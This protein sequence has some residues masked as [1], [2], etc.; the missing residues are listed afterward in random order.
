ML[1]PSGT[2]KEIDAAIAVFSFGSGV[3]LHLRST[4]ALA[5]HGAGSSTGLVA[6]AHLAGDAQSSIPPGVR[7]FAALAIHPSAP[8]VVAM[9]ALV[10][11]ERSLH[12]WREPRNFPPSLE[13]RNERSEE[14]RPG[15][16]GASVAFDLNHGGMLVASPLQPEPQS[17]PPLG[18]S[19]C[20]GLVRV[21]AM[22]GPSLGQF[23]LTVAFSSPSEAVLSSHRLPAS[24]GGPPAEALVDDALREWQTSAR[25]TRRGSRLAT[26]ASA[27]HRGLSALVERLGSPSKDDR[28]A[29]HEILVTL[30]GRDL[31]FDASAIP[32]EREQAADRWRQWLQENAR[33]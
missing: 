19:A 1:L 18:W 29:A 22:G 3:E 27:G 30:V 23:A 12:D 20:D 31:G 25:R 28:S 7:A 21:V 33:D 24:R 26:L 11:D 17:P 13:F 6:H 32:N 2:L 5:R 8:N 4:P 10:R 9:E 15:P 14:R 16:P